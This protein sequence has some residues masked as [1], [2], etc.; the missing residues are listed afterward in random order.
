MAIDVVADSS[1][2]SRASSGAR[3]PAEEALAPPASPGGHKPSVQRKDTP[4]LQ[5]RRR[6]R[7]ASGAALQWQQLAA[8]TRRNLLIRARA[9]KTNLLLVLQAVLFIALIWVVDRAVCASRQRQPAY[10]RVETAAAQPVGPIPDCSDN[11]F[12][13]AGQPC[14]TFLYAPAGDP[15]AE[16]VVHG[17][18]A[19]NDPPLPP[20]HVLGLPNASAVDA[21][22]L[23][24]PETALAAVIFSTPDGAASS[25]PAGASQ[26]ASIP[27]GAAGTTDPTLS[28]TA[29]P[30]T[31]SLPGMAG[32]VGAVPGNASQSNS[33][34]GMP[35]G[36]FAVL[37]GS[38][39]SDPL[40][41]GAAQQQQGVPA[42]GLPVQGLPAAQ[43]A[44]A[45]PLTFSIQ[46]NS[47]VQWFKGR[48]QHPNTY[49]QLPL[50]V[51]V[52]REIA[53]HLTGNASLSWEVGLAQFPHPTAKSPSMIGQFAPTFLF[54][55]IMFQFVLLVHDV[56]AEKEGRARQ[57]M[58]TMG[59]RPLP[60]WA[61]WVLFQGLLAAVEACLLVG[62]GYAFGFKLFTR[63]AFGLSFLLLLLV[64]LAMTSFG[65]FVASFLH[66]ASA[67]VPAGFMLFVVAWVV[68]IV[69]AFGFP[70]NASYSTV[71]V[72]VFSAMPWSLLSKGVQDLAAATDGRLH[73]IP[74]ADRFAYCQPGT[75][76]P[77][78]VALAGSYWQPSCVMP[79][80]QM[81][82]VLAVQC[83][84]FM[85]LAIYLDAVLPDAMGVRRPPWF[86]LQPSYWLRSGSRR[87]LRAAAGAL[88]APTEAE[89]GL[90]VDPDVAEEAQRQRRRCTA[91]LR[92]AGAGAA[93][94]AEAVELPAGQAGAAQSGEQAGAAQQAQTGG[95][96]PDKK[97]GAELAPAG[98]T[99]AV[100]MFG[101]RK[102]YKRG[103]LFRRKPFVAVRGNWLGVHQGECFA[104]LGPN[105]AGKST[106]MNCLT[107]VLP[108]DGGDALVCGESIASAGGMDRV[109]PL[110]G[111]CP[112]FDVLFEQLTGRE[113]L[114]LFG[115]I[116]GL[117]KGAAQDEAARLLDEVR[118][119]EAGG[120]RAGAYSGGMKRRL[121]VAIALLGDPQVVYLDEPTTGLDPISRRHLWD[122][123]DRAKR[124][125]AIVL[126]THSMEEAD[127]LGDRIG[128]MA[129]GRLRCL[130]NSLRL[131]SRFGSGY[132]VSIRVLG[133]GG[134]G[135]A[136]A[137]GIAA[138][139]GAAGAALPGYVAHSSG[140]SSSYSNPLCE[141]QAEP[142]PAAVASAVASGG[143]SGGQQEQPGG[144][145]HQRDPVAARH[146]ASVKGLFLQQL[147]I[148]PCDESLDYVHFLVPYEHEQH[149]PA[150]FAHLKTNP[151]LGVVDVQLRMTPLEEV[152]LT[153][154]RKAELEHAQ[155]EGRKVALALEEEGVT[156]QVPIGADLIQSPA[157]H[158]W[159]ITWGQDPD[160]GELC[161]QEYW[162]D[163]PGAAPAAASG[164]VAP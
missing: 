141:I 162:R 16:A 121:S 32:A 26:A 29:A 130:G 108:F 99:Y 55:S 53:R 44:A 152:F 36:V 88:A 5:V 11:L 95:A 160:T 13:R 142:L 76:L 100:E 59:L 137:A 25:A 23:S 116:K 87:S 67:A 134:G 135:T 104:L 132:R 147:G 139:S 52:E 43:A 17:V 107:G 161:L 74:W 24:H 82:W 119:A 65:F 97:G 122:L 102:V 143:S 110:M 123:V 159:H 117:P 156:V 12:M 48:Y 89:S 105:G 54:A 126:T 155:L 151:M 22:L 69:I 144:Q 75:A 37:P 9:W 136:V 98:R 28:G 84:G 92:K 71:A 115:A 46:T 79:L 40:A 157:G 91:Y 164:P 51:A 31:A 140:L 78:G 106:T 96:S 111:Y 49:I 20:E 158:L 27:T 58:A 77:P 10:S 4:T 129:R 34:G 128:I 94:P 148:K 86:L 70:F 109:R 145:C 56:V 90:A 125:R 120:V 47:S 33:T 35:G 6:P 14:I 1:M 83:A 154:A 15:D 66:K 118:L 18:A 61:S 64:S 133:S 103:G 7:L 3:L 150:L 146:A 72:A 124:D 2:S 41:A 42:Q 57:M 62:F 149:L 138:A 38:A 39:A 80:G 19:R 131:K 114:L 60:F 68:L 93:L 21:W 63:N 127:I 81:Y 112:Q 30:G 50:Q 8:L 45:R 101:L 85:A 163:G 73:G 113:H 153:V